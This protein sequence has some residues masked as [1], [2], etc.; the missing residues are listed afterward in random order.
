[1]DYSYRISVPI[2]EGM[3]KD[4]QTLFPWGTQSAMIRKVLELVIIK[5][6]KDGYNTI[7][8]LISGTYNPLEDFE[9]ALREAE[10]VEKGRAI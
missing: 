3:R 6:K 7:S 9:K 2:S 4:L 1:M 5:M 10:K 8:L